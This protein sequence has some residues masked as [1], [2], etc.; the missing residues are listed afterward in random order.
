LRILPADGIVMVENEG[1]RDQPKPRQK[2]SSVIVQSGN[3]LRFSY[4]IDPPLR[5]SPYRLKG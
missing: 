1:G 5:L 4:H 2:I 3:K